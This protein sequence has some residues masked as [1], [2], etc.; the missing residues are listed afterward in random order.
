MKL[1]CS[2]VVS[3]NPSCLPAPFKTRTNKQSNK[4]LFGVTSKFYDCTYQCLQ[5][6]VYI[7]A[8]PTNPNLNPNIPK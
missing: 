1:I 5:M 6:A 3:G 7:Q 2:V 8:L 4:S